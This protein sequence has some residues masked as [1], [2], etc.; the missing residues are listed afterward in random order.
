MDSIPNEIINHIMISYLNIDDIFTCLLTTKKFHVLTDH[1]LLIYRNAK[2]GYKYCLD[3][4]YLCGLQLLSPLILDVTI[5]KNVCLY[6]YKL[7]C[8]RGWLYMLPHMTTFLDPDD[9]QIGLPLAYAGGHDHIVSWLCNI[10]GTQF[11]KN[12]LRTA[13]MNVCTNNHLEFVYRFTNI[14]HDIVSNFD[15]MTIAIKACKRDYLCVLIWIYNMYPDLK[16]LDLFPISCRHVHTDVMLWLYHS[17]IKEKLDKE[18]TSGVDCLMGRGVPVMYDTRHIYSMSNHELETVYH[19]SFY[20]SCKS[21]HLLIAKWL[22]DLV[23]LTYV[24]NNGALKNTIKQCE[25]YPHVVSWLS[26]LRLA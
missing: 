9:I 11:D 15:A 25:K 2:R 13:F 21:G 22:Y 4:G 17:I 1:Q 24:I 7:Y 26:T 8:Q 10:C 5:S 16:I 19:K 18:F 12:I 14:Q 3:N 23:P 20:N 6:Y